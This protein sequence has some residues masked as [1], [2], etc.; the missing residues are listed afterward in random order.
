MFAEFTMASHKRHKSCEPWSNEARL[1]NRWGNPVGDAFRT[2]NPPS[3][4]HA[5][6]R[7]A[8][9][10]LYARQTIRP[11]DHSFTRYF[12]TKVLAK[13]PYL[14]R[15]M[16]IRIVQHPER[17]VSPQSF[18]FPSFLI[19]SASRLERTMG[20]SYSMAARAMLAWAR[21]ERTAAPRLRCLSS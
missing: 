3:R 21:P 1:A 14:T 9:A 8:V 18:N 11:V 20:P 2:F 12:E 6:P 17:R 4:F 16:C 13:R 5:L 19:S 7:P 15:E 10:T